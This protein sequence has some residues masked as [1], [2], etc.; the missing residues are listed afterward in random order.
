MVHRAPIRIDG[1]AEPIAHRPPVMGGG[2]LGV[3]AAFGAA[4]GALAFPWVS[5][6][7]SR[8][9]RGALVQDAAARHCVSLTPEARAVLAEPLAPGV[10]R[11]VIAK[12]A[13]FLGARLAV[14]TLGSF[15]PAHLIWPLGGA[16]RTYVL[17]RLFDRYLEHG[18]TDRAVRID[19]G[20]ARRVRE[21]IERALVGALTPDS[22]PRPEPATID[23]HRDPVTALV[24]G[25]L[26]RAAGIPERLAQ[27][28]DSAFDEALRPGALD[29]QASA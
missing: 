10:R 22:Q 19:A 6:G 20:E 24:D 8:R 28:L 12:A 15:A 11:G 1:E 13:R 23:D 4:A 2:R 18:R 9:V 14:R 17:G 7:L 27:R 29:T 21:A 3:Y 16:I 26:S 5:D 25:V